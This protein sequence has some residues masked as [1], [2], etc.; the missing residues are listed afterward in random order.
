MTALMG[1]YRLECSNYEGCWLIYIEDMPTLIGVFVA[2]KWKHTISHGTNK[3]DKIVDPKCY[4]VYLLWSE[5]VFAIRHWP[6]KKL[7]Y[8][9]CVCEWISTQELFY[10]KFAY[11]NKLYLAQIIWFT[12]IYNPEELFIYILLSFMC[13][14]M[15]Y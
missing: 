3:K 14:S 15:S 1:K 10:K 11:Q 2:S 7:S 9:K 12:V 6:F 8:D 4:R 5:R 13:F